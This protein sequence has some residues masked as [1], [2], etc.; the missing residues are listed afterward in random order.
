MLKL[1]HLAL[2]GALSLTLAA[3]GSG[4]SSAPAGGVAK[5]SAT[6]GGASAKPAS[7]A[8]AAAGAPPSAAVVGQKAP[9]P[10]SPNGSVT[11]TNGE[12]AIEGTDTLKWQP[13]T[14][15]AKPGDK[16]TVQI[17]NGGN[18][19]HTFMSPA[20]S[21]AQTDV[22]TQ[23]TISLSFNAPAA[24]GAYQFWCNIPGHAEAGMVGEVIVQ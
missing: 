2:I 20:L 24:P 9:G 7:P 1:P 18:T 3:C 16:V 22:P 6:A 12:A 13:D 17:K 15:V 19:A 10:Y 14:I 23:K 5:P 21:V 11:V 8:G 4:G